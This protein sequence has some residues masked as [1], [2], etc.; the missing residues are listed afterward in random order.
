MKTEINPHRWFEQQFLAMLGTRVGQLDSDV[1]RTIAQ[2]ASATV[3]QH[4]CLDLTDG[5]AE[6]LTKLEQQSFIGDPHSNTPVIL[7]E[8]KLYLKRFYFLERRVADMIANRNSRLDGDLPSVDRLNEL[9]DNPE[10]KLAALLAVTRQL[11]IITG[12][13]GTGKTST[14]VKILA[15]LL[16]ADDSLDIKLAA[17]TGKAAMRLAESIRSAASELD[18]SFEPKVVTLHRLLGM[19]RDGRSFRHGPH[20]PITADLLVVDEASMIDLSLMH[21]LLEALPAE[22]RLI[23]LGDPDQLP[24]VDTGNVLAD[25]CSGEPLYSA[26][27]AV[28]AK[29]YVGDIPPSRDRHKL[30]DA[31][32]ML[33]RSYRFDPSSAIGHL[34]QGIRGGATP[35]ESSA[36]DKVQMIEQTELPEAETLLEPWQQFLAALSKETPAMDLLTAFDKA[37]ILTSRRTGDTGVDAINEAIEANLEEKGLKPIGQEFYYGRPVLI[38]RNDYNLGLFN[39]DVGIC[40]PGSQENQ[41]LVVFPGSDSMSQ[42]SFLASRLPAHETC[43]AMTVHKAQGS[44]FDHVSLLL[45]ESTDTEADSLMTRELIYTA[46]TRAKQT[47]TVYGPRETWHNALA[48]SSARVSGMTNFLEIKQ[49]KTGQ[50]D[51]FG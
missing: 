46:V 11:A 31:I 10:Q 26:E 16:E 35:F 23:L 43:F 44:E 4:T 22:T 5:P 14:V 41:H 51:L 40:I 20:H 19:R 28:L 29:P 49:T 34:A 36:D 13:P 24:S 7:S 27:F 1:E 6:L 12:G 38:T 33:T 2:L 45:S 25:L 8:G 47:I 42:K 18:L 50:L 30:S 37:R 48:R 15:I 17:P 3:S 39:G 9:F 32:C 21:R